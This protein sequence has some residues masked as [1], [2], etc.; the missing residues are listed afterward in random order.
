MR[1]R[2]LHEHRRHLPL[3]A[4]L[5]V[6]APR[7][8]PIARPR[9][10]AP[11]EEDQTTKPLQVVPRCVGEAHVKVCLGGRAQMELLLEVGAPRVHHHQHRSAH[12]PLRHNVESLS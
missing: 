3:F 6:I 4:L 9:E 1:D 7:L 10:C 8:L 12:A 5:G 2:T 11:V